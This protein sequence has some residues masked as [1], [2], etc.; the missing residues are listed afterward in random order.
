MEQTHQ[1]T[2]LKA[3]VNPRRCEEVGFCRS[4]RGRGREHEGGGLQ[5]TGLL[6][7]FGDQ[8]WVAAQGTSWFGVSE[9][10]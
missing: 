8:H 6:E 5:E 3:A 10:R 7:A 2:S 1:P 9:L 4:L